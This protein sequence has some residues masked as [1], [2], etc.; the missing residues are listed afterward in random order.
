MVDDIQII[1]T[2]D[3]QL[4][5]EIHPGLYVKVEGTLQPDGSV[6]AARVRSQEYQ[7]TGIVNKI[8]PN[9]W[10]VEDVFITIS[11]DTEIDGRVE[12]GSRVTAYAHRMASGA[13]HATKVE[14][15]EDHPTPEP[16]RTPELASP[17]SVEPSTTPTPLPPPTNEPVEES[18]SDTPSPTDTPEPEEDPEPTQGGE[19]NDNSGEEEGGEEHHET[20]LPSRTPSPTENDDGKEHEHTPRPTRTPRP[21]EDDDHLEYTRTPTPVHDD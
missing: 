17:T 8:T 6:L 9:R 21:T 12:V 10:Q 11:P 2:A 5:G 7:I 13:L 15:L 4:E 20:P 3:T 18:P 19:D 14:V 1:I 16:T